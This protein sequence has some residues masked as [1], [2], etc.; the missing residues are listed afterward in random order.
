[1]AA[2]LVS[3]TMI[4]VSDVIASG[5]WYQQLL[6]CDNEHPDHPEFGK[7]VNDEGDTVLLLHCWGADPVDPM[8][9][10]FVDRGTAPVGHGVLLFFEMDDFETVIDRIHQM[11]CEILEKRHVLPSGNE[12]IWLRDPDGF[13]VQLSS[14]YSVI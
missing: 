9:R 8:D 13:V 2:N 6:G 10:W 4:A 3:G 5:N 1:M 11:G 14:S 7:L 12:A